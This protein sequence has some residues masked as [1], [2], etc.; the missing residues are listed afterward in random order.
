[1]RKKCDE[2][3]E[4]YNLNIQLSSFKGNEKSR[5]FIDTDLALYGKIKNITDK[6]Y[7]SN[8]FKIDEKIVEKMKLL[9][10]IEWEGSFCEYTNAG[11]VLEMNFEKIKNEIN[12]EIP[13]EE[14]KLEYLKMCK[15]KNVGLTNIKY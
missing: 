8:S 2:F 1:M 5:K 13:K 12:L 10:I 14:I 9:D 11:Q 6:Y 3:S 7:Y 4:E 15:E